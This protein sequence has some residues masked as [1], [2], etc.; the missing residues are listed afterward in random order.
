MAVPFPVMFLA[1]VG[2]ESCQESSAGLVSFEAF[3]KEICEYFVCSSTFFPYVV[4][5]TY[6]GYIFIHGEGRYLS[7]FTSVISLICKSE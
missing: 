5:V 6:A 3:L 7:V 2:F 4:N 1:I